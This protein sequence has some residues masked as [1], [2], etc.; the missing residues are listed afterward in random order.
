[1]KTI[2]L[3]EVPA[4]VRNYVDGHK[5]EVSRALKKIAGDAILILNRKIDSVQPYPAVDTGK[6]KRS[7]RVVPRQFG[8]DIVNIAPYSEIMNDG[9]PA[10]RTPYLPIARW[11]AR[12]LKVP[13]S[14]VADARP[15][16]ARLPHFRFKGAAHASPLPQ[17]RGGRGIRGA[18]RVEELKKF[19]A[20]VKGLQR[21]IASRGHKPRQFVEEA[22]PDIE[23]MVDR[24]LK[25]ALDRARR[26]IG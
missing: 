11:T 22:L 19:A 10:H 3:H 18:R 12:K 9:A 17:V 24:E 4:F 16:H 2:R 14:F 23:R 6:M 21:K 5:R 15:Y 1:M 13:P 20:V 7:W 26:K 8:A 25:K